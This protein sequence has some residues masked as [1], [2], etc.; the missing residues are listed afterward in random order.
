M[1]PAERIFHTVPAGGARCLQ[2][3]FNAELLLLG[4][5]LVVFLGKET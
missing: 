5:I 4:L 3:V 2:L 1:L